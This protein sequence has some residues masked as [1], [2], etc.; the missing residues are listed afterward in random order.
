VVSRENKI[1]VACIAVAVPLGLA[2]TS[3]G[4]LPDWVGYVV[5]TAVGVLLPGFLT[6]RYREAGRV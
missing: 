6:G 2:V 3:V 4:G 5:I 1:I